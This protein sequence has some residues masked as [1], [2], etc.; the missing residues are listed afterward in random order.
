MCT[1]AGHGDTL[2]LRARWGAREAYLRDS[3][4]V[5][6]IRLTC[7]ITWEERAAGV[8]LSPEQGAVSPHPT[9]RE[10]AGEPDAPTLLPPAPGRRAALPELVLGAPL[11]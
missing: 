1:G 11:E 2:R 6:R 4:R 8:S 3:C 10:R 5:A 9:P 7:T